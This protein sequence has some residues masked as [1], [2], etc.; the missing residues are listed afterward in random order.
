[1]LVLL[2]SREKKLKEKGEKIKYKISTKKRSDAFKS[3]DNLSENFLIPLVVLPLP[4]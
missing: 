1:L 3:L 4:P 2:L